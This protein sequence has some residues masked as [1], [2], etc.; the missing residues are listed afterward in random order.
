MSVCQV[1]LTNLVNSH[2]EEH[3][4]WSVRRVIVRGP[5]MREHGTELQS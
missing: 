3:A 5:D 4:A 2:L 1:R